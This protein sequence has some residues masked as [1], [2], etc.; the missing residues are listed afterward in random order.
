LIAATAVLPSYF[1]SATKNDL[2]NLKLETQK[3]EPLP[4]FDQPT[5]E[6]IKDLNNKLSLIENTQN[7][8]IFLLSKVIN[9]IILKKIPS[10]KITQITYGSDSFKGRKISISGTAP[11]REILLLFRRALEDDAVFK[12]VD[13][14]IS[15]FVKGS[16]IQF[17]LNLIPS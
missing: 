13:L 14:P 15:N 10:I 8:K 11:S 9:A 1:L 16:N 2:I 17:S 12:K 6:V 4:L 5:L 3:Q 7:S